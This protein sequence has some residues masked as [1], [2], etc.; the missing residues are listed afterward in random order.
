M[1]SPYAIVWT[2]VY[3]D[4]AW[5]PCGGLFATT[6]SSL[7]FSACKSMNVKQEEM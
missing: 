2:G 6:G 1:Y 7:S 4:F 5:F 3:L